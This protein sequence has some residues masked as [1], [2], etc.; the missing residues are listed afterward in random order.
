MM[1][2]TIFENGLHHLPRE[3]VRV[4]MGTRTLRRDTVTDMVEAQMLYPPNDAALVET[5]MTGDLP[6]TPALVHNEPGGF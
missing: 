3:L 2:A 1:N 5:R 6:R 4:G